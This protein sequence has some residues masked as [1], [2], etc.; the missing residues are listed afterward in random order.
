MLHISI[1]VDLSE[2]IVLLVKAS[3]ALFLD[4]SGRAAAGGSPASVIS[5]PSC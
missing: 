3:K 1:N 4:H 5:M 2:D